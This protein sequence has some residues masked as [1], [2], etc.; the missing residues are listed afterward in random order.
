MTSMHGQVELGVVGIFSHVGGSHVSGG[1]RS[2]FIC[3]NLRNGLQSAIGGRWLDGP[4][5]LQCKSITTTNPSPLST[6]S[7]PFT[8]RGWPWPTSLLLLYIVH[9][10]THPL[11][12][13]HTSHRHRSGFFA[14]GCTRRGQT[15]SRRRCPPRLH[16]DLHCAAFLLHFFDASVGCSCNAPFSANERMSERPGSA[17]RLSFRLRSLTARDVRMN[18]SSG[19]Q[20]HGSKA[21]SLVG[22]ADLLAI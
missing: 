1:G 21:T 19:L 4:F 16:F 20:H 18:G 13:A 22:K 15:A 3:D 11:P 8:D 5:S 6:S 17:Q 10:P 7:P 12:S 2:I 9:R 14:A